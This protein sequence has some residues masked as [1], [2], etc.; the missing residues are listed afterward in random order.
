MKKI[1]VVDDMSG[2]RDFN[3]NAVYEILGEN[4]QVD[5]ASSAEDAYSKILE[6]NTKP[7]DIVITDLQ[8]ENSYEPKY[9]GEWLVEQIKSL[10]KY[11]RTK[12]IMVSA[13]YNVRTIAE[14]LNVDCIPKTTA[15]KCLSAYRELLEG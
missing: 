14:S 7:Y 4:A 1:L 3:T 6:N 15:V 5:E 13:S 12:I 11:Y 8:M 10:P 9:A 2:W